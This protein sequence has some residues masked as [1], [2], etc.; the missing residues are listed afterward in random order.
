MKMVIILEL[1]LLLPFISR[2]QDKIQLLPKVAISYTSESYELRNEEVSQTNMSYMTT[3]IGLELKY[4][5]FSVY[6]DNKFW[7]TPEFKC[8]SFTPSQARF[9]IGISYHVTNKIKVTAEHCCWH[10]IYTDNDKGIN[11][12]CG[13]K[14]EI[15]ISY[16]Y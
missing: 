2:A 6:S 10:P 16:G 14:S 7:V 5:K 13:G 8:K 1:L 15:T 9:T 11:G 12:I 4:K 3:K